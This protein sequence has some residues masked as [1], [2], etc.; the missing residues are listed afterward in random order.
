MLILP[1]TISDLRSILELQYLAY[2]EEAELLNNFDIPQ[3]NE[4]LDEIEEDFFNGVIL[5]A[6]DDLGHI[7]G[8][9]R[10]FLEEGTTV[11][12]DR[13]IVH[14]KKQG[15]GIGSKLLETVELTFPGKR[16]ELFSSDLSKENLEFYEKRGYVAFR[17]QYIQPQ[18]R[19]LYMEKTLVP[20]K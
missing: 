13:M 5:K 3:M 4:T 19:G 17:E 20:G 16:F 8:S 7:I 18:V 9:I 6:V 2:L 12:I 14:P 1:A 10:A 15:F 11:K